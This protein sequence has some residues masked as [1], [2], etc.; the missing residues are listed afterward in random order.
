MALAHSIWWISPV[1]PKTQVL[2]VHPKSERKSLNL[3]KKPHWKLVT[4][5]EV[6]LVSK[7]HLF[8]CLVAQESKL[9]SKFLGRLDISGSI[10]GYIHRNRTYPVQ[11]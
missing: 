9:R 10:T 3:E 4:Y 7:F 6:T 5:V 8:W 1:S 2:R 11:G